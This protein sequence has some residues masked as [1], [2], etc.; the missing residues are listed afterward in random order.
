MEENDE[1]LDGSPREDMEK[2]GNT[3]YSTTTT[4]SSGSLT[5]NMMS[6]LVISPSKSLARPQSRVSPIRK[7]SVP[8]SQ[9]GFMSDGDDEEGRQEA[10]LYDGDL[11]DAQDMRIHSSAVVK[12]SEVIV[13]HYS[14]ISIIC[15]LFTP[16]FSLSSI[17][18]LLS[19][20]YIIGKVWSL[21]LSPSG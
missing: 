14:S 20:S 8:G 19:H 12:S 13:R 5:P 15:F 10:E 11:G 4:T 17:S 16:M 6:S 18:Y 3:T 21:P 9:G 1:E 7:P 2:E